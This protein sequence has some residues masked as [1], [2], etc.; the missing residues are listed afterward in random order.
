MFDLQVC[1]EILGAKFTGIT[2]I[3]GVWDFKSF[4]ARLRPRSADAGIQTKF[5]LQFKATEDGRK[6][7]VRHKGAVDLRVEFGPW[8]VLLP[9]PGR[10]DLIPHRDAV[11]RVAANK[12]WPEF[13]GGIVPTLREFYNDE[14]EH[15]VN[16]PA[17]DKEEMLAF[18]T[19]GPDPPSTSG[20]IAW[21]DAVESSDSGDDAG[22]EA[23]VHAGDDAG[24]VAGDNAT[25]DA[26]DDAGVV[27]GDEDTKTNEFPFPVGTFVAFQFTSGLFR[28]KVVHIY[29]DEKDLCRVEFTDGDHGDYDGDEIHYAVQL[30]QREFNS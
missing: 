15:P 12:D 4:L 19:R 28:G 20:W 2:R 7:L 23:R 18:L 29:P 17:A 21:D 9:Y 1:R 27:A 25:V 10:A 11:P 3:R 22:D 16:I 14:F 13:E 30:Y 6:I 5:S 26:G 8:E 24:I